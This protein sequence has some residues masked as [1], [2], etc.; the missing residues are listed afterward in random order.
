MKLQAVSNRKLYIQIADQIR[1]QIH[2]GEVEP[3]RQLPS[4]RDLALSL[5]VSRPTVREALIALEVAGLVE[6]R[7]GVGAFVRKRENASEALPEMN[8]SPLEIMAVRRLL[9]PEAAALASQNLS[10]E[11]Q[12][13]LAETLRRMRAE[14][15]QGQWSAESDRTLHMTLADA[16]GNALLREMLDGLWN[17]R[18]GAVDT[19][20][21]QHLADIGE[22]RDHILADHE[23]IVAAVL[24]GNAEA[25][26]TAMARHLAFA[27]EAMLETWE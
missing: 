18:Q 21:H 20:F 16:C 6:V 26:R 5:G 11:G 7:V 4:E 8:A 2:A 23:A 14:N 22:V 9:E 17:S 24:S 10:A 19:R 13:R 15:Q 12:A 3:G 25:S 27:S 1:D